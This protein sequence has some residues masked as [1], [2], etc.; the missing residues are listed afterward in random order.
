[1]D[2]PF[3]SAMGF[4]NFGFHPLVVF[5]MFYAGPVWYFLIPLFLWWSRKQEYE[6]DHWAVKMLGNGG[7]LKNA[8]RKLSDN[9]LSDPEAHPLYRIFHFTHPQVFERLKR[10]DEV[11]N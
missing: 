3:F 9:N 8:L 5:L 6:A 2:K 7:H 1:L 4:T 11:D 10:I